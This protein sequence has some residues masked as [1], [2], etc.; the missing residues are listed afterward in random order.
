MTVMPALLVAVPIAGAGLLWLARRRLAREHWAGSVA[1]AA[2]LS[3]IVIVAGWLAMPSQFAL[4]SWRPST[5]FQA[6]I[7]LVLDSSSWMLVL[8]SSMLL[9]SALLTS[10]ARPGSSNA[11]TRSLSL[12]YTAL[13]IAAFQAANLLTVILFWTLADG[14]SFFV[15]VSEADNIATVRGLIRR[16]GVQSAS[17]LLVMAAAVS[18]SEG[19]Q[20]IIEG[21]QP[22]LLGAAV[23]LRVGLW[24]LHVGLPQLPGVRRG[25]GALVRLFPP[26][27]AL[28]LL[29]RFLPGDTPVWV[30][31]TLLLLAAASI[32]IGG[33]RWTSAWDPVQ[34]RPYLVLCFAGLGVAAAYGAV[35]V[36]REAAIATAFGMLIVGGAIS[37]AVLH[38]SWHRWLLVLVGLLASGMPY[39]PIH[40]SLLM[41][42]E[43]G[44]LEPVLTLVV[45]MTWVGLLLIAA[46]MFRLS[47][48][49]LVEW[50]SG[51]GFVRS[52]YA[53]GLFGLIGAVVPVA[54][55]LAEPRPNLL[56][57]LSFA[58]VVGLAT[59]LAFQSFP[60]LQSAIQ[61]GAKLADGLATN[62]DRFAESTFSVG[63]NAAAK[64]VR[65]LGAV[66]EGK[67]AL[68]WVYVFVL[69]AA[70]LLS[71]TGGG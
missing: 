15:L 20:E 14:L 46:G 12:V 55:R 36:G 19:V 53:L 51:E 4:S 45:V 6:R 1:T 28:A 62:A 64:G 26:A 49:P 37:Q 59:F 67:A 71:G 38:E 70:L 57:S 31:A 42:S 48:R 39:S 50:E 54:V 68:L 23:L 9:L 10:A 35:P 44:P 5:L 32:L 69:M 30:R 2:L 8:G 47:R 56:S 13:A 29:G 16:F 60:W 61:G 52:A 33:F 41:L 34:A 27:M 24:P 18:A 21:A 58:V 43:V 3:G 25:M 7:D 63:L 17:I 11:T 65:G 66:F 40:R 22:A